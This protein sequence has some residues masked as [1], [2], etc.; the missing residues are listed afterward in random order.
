MAWGRLFVP[1]GRS[2]LGGQTGEVVQTHS[3]IVNSATLNEWRSEN[4]GFRGA[5]GVILRFGPP[6]LGGGFGVE[7]AQ[8]DGT[9]SFST[10]HS[11]SE[12]NRPKGAGC[13]DFQH[14]IGDFVVRSV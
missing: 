4:R 2:F 10:N 9:L 12:S 1:E 8:G 6:F 3:R 7:I 5:W 11:I 14:L 13:L